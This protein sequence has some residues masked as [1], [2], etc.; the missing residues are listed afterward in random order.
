MLNRGLA[1]RLTGKFQLDELEHSA[2]PLF[3]SLGLFTDRHTAH[4]AI[5]PHTTHSRPIV[6][7][8]S[9]RSLPLPCPSW[10]S[11]ASSPICA[12]GSSHGARG[13]TGLPS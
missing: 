8:D 1:Q 9:L 13:S 5:A 4:S 2:D 3:M 6:I 7:N 12:Q 11:C 10:S